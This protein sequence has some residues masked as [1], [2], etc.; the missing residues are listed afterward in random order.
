VFSTAI[1]LA[2]F[3]A[4][5]SF[6]HSHAKRKAENPTSGKSIFHSPARSLGRRTFSSAKAIPFPRS[7]SFLASRRAVSTFKSAPGST[8]PIS[9]RE[10][11]PQQI[12]FPICLRHLNKRGLQPARLAFGLREAAGGAELAGDSASKQAGV[13]TNPLTP[14]PSKRLFNRKSA[15]ANLP[16]CLSRPSPAV[17]LQLERGGSCLAPI[18]PHFWL[19]LLYFQSGA[20]TP[21]EFCVS[22][23]GSMAPEF[24][25]KEQIF[26][27]QSK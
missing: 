4:F 18:W 5:V 9:S 16:K 8:H 27:F 10:N 22:W 23:R 21:E 15:E 14:P 24:S 20:A 11:G 6:F 2:R 12:N 7:L 25:T 13:L 3:S 26:R 19:G 17:L 1:D